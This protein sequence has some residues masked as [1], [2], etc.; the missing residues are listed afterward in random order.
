[1]ESRTLKLGH[2]YSNLLNLYGDKGNVVA[3]K[4][5]CEWRGI[6]LEINEI[7]I[8]EFRRTR[9]LFYWRRTG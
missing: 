1:M 8:G 5:R 9:Y 7:N 3:L 2:L 4:K 6:T